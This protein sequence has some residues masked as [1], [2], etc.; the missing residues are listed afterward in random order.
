MS[1]VLKIEDTVPLI[2]TSIRDSCIETYK[3]RNPR[4]NWSTVWCCGAFY[5]GGP[6]AKNGQ[7]VV[8]HLFPRGS[9]AAYKTS[10]CL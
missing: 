7:T 2:P 8:N 5:F 9:G 6:W 4:E 10:Y 3:K 1:A